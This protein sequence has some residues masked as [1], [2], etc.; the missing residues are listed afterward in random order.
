MFSRI[1]YNNTLRQIIKPPKNLGSIA[2]YYS[3]EYYLRIIPENLKSKDDKKVEVKVDML[4]KFTDINNFDDSDSVKNAVQK[5]TNSTIHSFIKKN[6]FK[7]IKKDAIK[8]N[9]LHSI[10][11]DITSWSGDIIKFDITNLT[12]K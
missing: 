9:V 7:D 5:Y 2:S 11:E 6:N 4:I 8:T 12:N 3:N 1:F 10:S